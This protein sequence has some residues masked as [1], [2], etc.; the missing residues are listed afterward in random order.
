MFQFRSKN[1]S[2]TKTKNDIEAKNLILGCHLSAT[3]WAR[4]LAVCDHGWIC[5]LRWNFI[6]TV[7]RDFGSCFTGNFR[8]SG[9]VEGQ[10]QRLFPVLVKGQAAGQNAGK[11]QK[12]NGG[13]YLT[14]RTTDFNSL[15]WYVDQHWSL[16]RYI[17]SRNIFVN[18]C[19]LLWN[20]HRFYS[21]CYFGAK[22]QTV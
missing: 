7:T 11:S 1:I 4:F 10:R 14:L 13:T 19:L 3:S 17:L 8:R 20:T 18:F 6:F 12:L 16:G 15:Q 5:H 21:E 2:S 9:T 22:V